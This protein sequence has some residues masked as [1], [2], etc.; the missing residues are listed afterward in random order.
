MSRNVMERLLHQLCVERATKQRFKEDPEGLLSR[1]VLTE[2][3]KRMF[4]N[5]DVKAMQAHGANPMLTMGFWQENA[6]E[7]S[8]V[9]YIKA[10]RGGTDNGQPTF[11]AALKQ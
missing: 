2:D 5:F 11:S 8:P 4:L 7:R 3:E 10:L 1:Y 6:P 9:A